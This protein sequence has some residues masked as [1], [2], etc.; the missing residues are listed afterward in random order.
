MPPW[1]CANAGAPLAIVYPEEGTPLVCGQAGVLAAAPNPDGARLF[2]NFLFSAECQQLMSDVGGIRSFH[3][4]VRM[5]PGRL[6]MSQIK[7]L[8]P[9]PIQLA[10]SADE[11]KRRCKIL[12]GS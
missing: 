1:R 4:A 7:A 6:P 5:R 11:I 12:F 9:E 3:P 8:R 2:A 10:K